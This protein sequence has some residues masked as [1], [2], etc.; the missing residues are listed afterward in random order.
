MG[1]SKIKSPVYIHT[2]ILKDNFRNIFIL[3][4]AA[5]AAPI[6]VVEFNNL[7]MR[8]VTN[9]NH[10]CLCYAKIYTNYKHGRA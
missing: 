8:Y 6:F 2:F 7:D 10:Y 9:N 5:R 3:N 4:I 1:I